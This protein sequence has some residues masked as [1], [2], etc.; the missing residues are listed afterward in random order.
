MDEDLQVD[1]VLL[2]FECDG[3][4]D[5][6]R[7]VAQE[8][9]DRGWVTDRYLEELVKR[10]ERYPTGLPTEPVQTAIPHVEASE[11]RHPG[12]VIVRPRKAVTFIEMGSIDHEVSAQI[13]F[14]ILPGGSHVA[15]LASLVKR[16]QRT[17]L[18][19][20]LMEVSTEDAA[21]AL[22]VV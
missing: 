3:Q 2:N 16:F 14:F 8:L 5:L 15:W 7:L 17:Q 4:A 21:R 9:F 11:V 13:I 18:L 19:S 20:E 6:F 12:L 1:L 22:F 10:E